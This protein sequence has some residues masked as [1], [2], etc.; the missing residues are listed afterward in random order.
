MKKLFFFLSLAALPCAAQDAPAPGKTAPDRTGTYRF[1]LE[2]GGDKNTDYGVALYGGLHRLAYRGLTEAAGALGVKQR[3]YLRP[4]LIPASIVAL[5]TPGSYL[6]EYY[7]HGAYLREYGF[8]AG[9]K[10]KWGWNLGANGQADSQLVQSAGG[11]EARQMWLGG[12]MAA[13]QLWLLEY[14]KEMYR[15]GRMTLAAA[16]PLFAASND[17]GYMWNNMKADQNLNQA[18]NDSASW[19]RNFKTRN[20]NSLQIADEFARKNRDAIDMASRMDPAK[21]WAIATVLHYLWTGDDGF[22]APALPVFGV[23]IGYSPKVNLTPVGPENYHYIFLASG[24]RLLSVYKRSGEAIEGQISGYGAEAGP[25][26]LFGLGLTPGY[27]KWEL[28]ESANLAACKSGSGWHIKADLPVYKGLG[29]TGKYTKKDA[30]YL[31]GQPA[32]AG[33]YGYAGLSLTF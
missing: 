32:G 19:L 14:E 28:P 25:I 4:L 18:S 8:E 31:L 16:G 15:S 12:G 5:P 17:L 20:G 7:G 21:Y 23:R 9:T 13:T 22:Y 26:N 6:H 30:G 1:I 27:D 10:Y 3:W 29:L 33:G 11:Y 2:P 24:G